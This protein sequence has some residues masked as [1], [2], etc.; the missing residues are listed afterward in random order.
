MHCNTCESIQASKTLEQKD[1]RMQLMCQV[2]RL[3]LGTS[4]SKQ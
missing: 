3:I 2:L 4:G 1:C